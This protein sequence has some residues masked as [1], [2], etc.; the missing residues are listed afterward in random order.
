MNSLNLLSSLRAAAASHAERMIPRAARSKHAS[1]SS[2]ENSKCP[3][4]C[5]LY[6]IEIKER[7]REKHIHQSIRRHV[8][9]K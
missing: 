9:G 6:R 8:G 5:G 2:V 1:T 4:N 3:Y 7:R